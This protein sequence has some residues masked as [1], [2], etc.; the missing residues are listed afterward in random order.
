MT[1]EEV[2]QLV[3]KMLEGT[4]PSVT[5]RDYY[6]NEFIQVLGDRFSE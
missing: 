5:T 6:I 3:D 1:R 4:N 2:E